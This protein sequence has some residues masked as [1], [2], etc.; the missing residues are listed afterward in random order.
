MFNKEIIKKLV[1]ATKDPI[2]MISDACLTEE[3]DHILNGGNDTGDVSS[4]NKCK[5]CGEEID[6]ENTFCDNDCGLRYK[7]IL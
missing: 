1:A 5:F 7:D 4:S 3:F 6:N 2:L